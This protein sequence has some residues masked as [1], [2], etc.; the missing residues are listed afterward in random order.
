VLAEWV[1]LLLAVSFRTAWLVGLQL[2]LHLRTIPIQ[3]LRQVPQA[4][5]ALWLELHTIEAALRA[6]R[7]V[8]PLTLAAAAV[9]VLLRGTLM[10][11]L[12]V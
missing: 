10:A 7:L 9:V 1:V 6:A 2:G 3:H 5:L 8:A 11:L 12:L 4:A